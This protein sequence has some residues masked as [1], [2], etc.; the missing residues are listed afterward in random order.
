M[1]EPT[2]GKRT[3]INARNWRAIE[4]ALDTADK[5]FVNRLRNQFPGFTE[6]DFRL[7]ML[8]RLKLTT[9]Q[10]RVFQLRFGEAKPCLS[11]KWLASLHWKLSEEA[12]PSIVS[13]GISNIGLL[14]HDSIKVTH[15]TDCDAS[16]LWVPVKHFPQDLVFLECK[17]EFSLYV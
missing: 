2:A 11:V 10:Q 13:R 6:E 15:K 17:G 4:A 1:L 12:V 9:A 5:G 16:V 8:T 7:C 3:I 14:A